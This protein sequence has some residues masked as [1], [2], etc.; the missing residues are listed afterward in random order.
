MFNFKELLLDKR[1]D[2]TTDPFVGIRKNENGDMVFRLP[3]GFDIFPRV[4]S[5]E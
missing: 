4:I 3:V 2:E 5:T 1:N